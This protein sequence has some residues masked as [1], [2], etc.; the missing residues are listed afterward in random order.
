M[1]RPYAPALALLLLAACAGASIAGI[2]EGAVPAASGGGE[3]H[4]RVTLDPDGAATMTT[5]FS[6]RPSRSLV[7]GTWV[8]DGDR[9]AVNLDNGRTQLVFDYSGDRLVARDWDRSQW[10]DQGPGV[11][12]RR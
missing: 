11:L 1:S 4:V 5:A 7:K 2:Y 12:T 3:R 9:V 6:G 8:R 10:G